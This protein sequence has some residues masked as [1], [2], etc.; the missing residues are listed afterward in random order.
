MKSIFSMNRFYASL[1]GHTLT[2][3][4]FRKAVRFARDAHPEV[5]M[6]QREAFA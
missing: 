6:P 3:T 2:K 5:H 4:A 1:H